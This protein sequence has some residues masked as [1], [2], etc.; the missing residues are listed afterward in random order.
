MSEERRE[1]EEKC[2]LFYND[3]VNELVRRESE[4]RKQCPH[5]LLRHLP[6]NVPSASLSQREIHSGTR[7]FPAQGNL[8]GGTERKR[9]FSA[10]GHVSHTNYGP[11]R[12]RFH[13]RFAAKQIFNEICRLTSEIA[14]G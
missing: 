13:V 11:S 5:L 6:L 8:V 1:R 4:A 14:V 2:S 10:F 3:N 12:V 9:A 7:A